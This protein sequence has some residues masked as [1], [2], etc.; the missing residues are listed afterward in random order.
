M[1]SDEV[2]CKLEVCGCA[3]RGEAFGDGLAVFFALD[4]SSAVGFGPTKP[5]LALAALFCFA[6]A[7]CC[8]LALGCLPPLFVSTGEGNLGE[9]IPPVALAFAPAVGFHLAAT[10]AP[11][12]LGAATGA[13]APPSG[14]KS[15]LRSNDGRCP[16]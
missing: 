12:A 11:Q 6:A 2:A 14:A 7:A 10:P 5:D 13:A 1:S 15:A 8:R 9:I 16:L 3:L 4:I